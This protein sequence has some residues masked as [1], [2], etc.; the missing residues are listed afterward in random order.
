MDNSKARNVTVAE[1]SQISNNKDIEELRVVSKL[2]FTVWREI[3][4][5]EQRRHIHI[6]QKSSVQELTLSQTWVKNI[7]SNPKYTG[8]FSRQQTHTRTNWN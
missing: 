5:S 6:I 3:L 8:Y 1:L 7:H 2:F 4:K